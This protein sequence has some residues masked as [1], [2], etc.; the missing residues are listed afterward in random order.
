MTFEE[1]MELWEAFTGGYVAT[2]EQLTDLVAAAEVADSVHPASWPRLAKLL[3]AH[4]GFQSEKDARAEANR[5]RIVSDL[6]VYPYDA[7][8]WVDAFLIA[9]RYSINFRGV[10]RQSV[11]YIEWEM[12]LL[13]AQHGLFTDAL[14]VAA[15]SMWRVDQAARLLADGFADVRHDPSVTSEELD[16]FAA[17]ITAPV[18]DPE[19]FARNVRATTVALANMIH[20][21]KNHMR[22]RWSHSTHLMPI[23]F[24]PQGNGKSTAVEHLMSPIEQFCTVAGFDILEDNSRMYDLSV[25]P[26][27]FFEEL[28]GIGKADVEKIKGLMTAKCRQLRQAYEKA[29]T[30]TLVSTFIGCTNHDVS[31]LIRDTSGNRRFLQIETPKMDRAEIG[32][33]NALAIWRSVDEDAEAPLYANA[34]DL[35]AVHALQS[36]QRHQSPVERWMFDD[37]T[38]PQTRMKSSELFAEHFGPWL[39]AMD[40][41]AEKRWS[42]SSFGKELNRLM[43]AS[44]CADHIRKTMLSGCARYQI[45][46]GDAQP[47]GQGPES[48][49]APILKLLDGARA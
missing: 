11:S 27:M 10:M 3:I 24:G 31:T 18:D 8:Q 32:K 34:S 19:V 47:T 43:K 26:V 15:F 12:K 33:F 16:R 37:Q 28:A 46:K 36:E 22:K 2:L 38:I 49:A 21:T 23:L 48:L 9:R 44:S 29:T 13:R 41:G 14:L 20:R 5:C 42:E 40:P 17:Y 4:G 7:R 6:G 39:R 25:L 30:A 45:G 1:N 35:E